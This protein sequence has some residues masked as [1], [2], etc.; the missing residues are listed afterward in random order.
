MAL[1]ALL[2]LHSRVSAF[3]DDPPLLERL[4]HEPVA[5]GQPPT[6][7]FGRAHQQIEREWTR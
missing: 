5:Q 2:G 4:P 3:I 7:L 1:R 6:E